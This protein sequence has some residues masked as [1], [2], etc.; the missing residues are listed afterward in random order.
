M[1]NDMMSKSETSAKTRTYVQLL[2]SYEETAKNFWSSYD[3]ISE[4]QIFISYIEP[5]RKNRASALE[6]TAGMRQIKLELVYLLH[7]L[8]LA[9]PEECRGEDHAS[10]DTYQ[11][12]HSRRD[13]PIRQ[14]PRVLLQGLEEQRVQ[15][16]TSSLG[17]PLR[18]RSLLLAETLNLPTNKCIKMQELREL[19]HEYAQDTAAMK[20]PVD[21]V[22]DFSNA[23][24]KNPTY[25]HARL[26]VA[27]LK[28]NKLM[29]ANG[30][31]EDD[32]HASV[33]EYLELLMTRVRKDI[34]AQ[35]CLDEIWRTE[36]GLKKRSQENRQDQEAL[37]GSSKKSR[38]EPDKKK[39]S[40]PCWV[41]G[42]AHGKYCNWFKH[43]LKGDKDVIWAQSVNGKKAIALNAHS[44][45]NGVHVLNPYKYLDGS[46]VKEYTKEEVDKLKVGTSSK[47]TNAVKGK[48]AE[49]ILNVTEKEELDEVISN[50]PPET[51]HQPPVNKQVEKLAALRRLEN[52]HFTRCQIFVDK[53]TKKKFS[54]KFLP[55]PGSLSKTLSGNYISRETCDELVKNFGVKIY[56]QKESK[57]ID[58][59]TEFGKITEVSEHVYFYL[60]YKSRTDDQ[61][62]RAVIKAYVIPDLIV[63]I[64]I[65][66]NDLL[67][68]CW[69]S[70]KHLHGYDATLER[71]GKKDPQLRE[72]LMDTYGTYDMDY[73]SSPVET[74]AKRSKST[75]MEPRVAE[76]LFSLGERMNN[77]Q[78]V[79]ELCHLVDPEQKSEDEHDR[80][81][82]D[83]DE[84]ADYEEGEL[85]T[86]INGSKEGLEEIKKLLEKV[87][88]VFSRELSKNPA[89]VKPYKIDID[90]HNGKT[91]SRRR[92][93]DAKVSQRR[94]P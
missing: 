74:M 46:V 19:L 42:R 62:L 59:P 2:T 67:Y 39:E 4:E 61:V 6:K 3:N 77:P 7:D 87:K 65:G 12:A 49:M 18:T 73:D 54:T 1:Q 64:L 20:E 66:K 83:A 93:T 76:M 26:W 41:C 72:W 75:G 89:K 28:E 45:H 84:A 32:P 68:N 43:P 63:P 22:A 16:A 23:M 53:S 14:D 27:V 85:P 8:R 13:F 35:E 44:T 15:R 40:N 51:V 5:H 31:L 33:P 60:E 81:Y 24:V 57:S 69:I 25:N 88:K 91:C 29:K 30:T 78:E 36:V 55:D 71:I 56:N 10:E 58:F 9:H 17:D 82:E 50:L 70:S 37:H 80:Y 52:A 11:K 79:Q 48:M 47:T 90:E 21:F 38:N 94:Q 34:Y 92:G 86:Q